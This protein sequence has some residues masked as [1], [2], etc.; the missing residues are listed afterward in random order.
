MI[1]GKETG[2]DVA[3]RC[4][5]RPTILDAFGVSGTRFLASSGQVR[6]IGAFELPRS[7]QGAGHEFIRADEFHETRERDGRWI[8]VHHAG[9]LVPECRGDLGAPHAGSEIDAAG[10][11]RRSRGDRLWESYN[12]KSWM[13]GG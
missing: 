4:F 5:G 2:R 8:R 12:R 3:S 1:I 10:N 13:S 7:T 9:I 11:P 6:S